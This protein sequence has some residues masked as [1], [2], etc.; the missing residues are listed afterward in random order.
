MIVPDLRVRKKLLKSERPI[1]GKVSLN[2]CECRG[3]KEL[4]FDWM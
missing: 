4:D 2:P 1:P 3:F